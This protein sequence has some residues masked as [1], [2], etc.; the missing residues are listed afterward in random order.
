MLLH[1]SSVWAALNQAIV[2][3]VACVCVSVC[4]FRSVSSQPKQSEPADTHPAPL[5]EKASPAE[6]PVAHTAPKTTPA[7][8]SFVT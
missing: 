5:L 8:V 7:A 3:P 1:T 6:R 2:R 4:V